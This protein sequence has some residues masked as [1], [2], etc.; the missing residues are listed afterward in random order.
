MFAVTTVAFDLLVVILAPRGLWFQLG[1]RSAMA[2]VM[3]L[4]ARR[5]D[6]C[7]WRCSVR[8]PSTTPPI[9]VLCGLGICGALIIAVAWRSLRLDLNWANGGGPCDLPAAVV[10][11]ILW[12]LIAIECSLFPALEEFIYR[13]LL[14]GALREAFNARVAIMVSSLAFVG[15]HVVYGNLSLW[16]P[17]A[18]IVLSWSYARSG[19][20]WVPILFHSLGNLEPWILWLL[21]CPN[22]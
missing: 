17:V 15:L 9:E 1:C 10:L 12:G 11:S 13:S 3:A 16:H 2:S 4:L 21:G 18:A 20:I 5:Y 22:G 19:T 7:G 14:M 8:K 6:L